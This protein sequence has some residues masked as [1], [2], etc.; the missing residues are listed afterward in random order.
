M[1]TSHSWMAHDLIHDNLG[2]DY[3][4]RNSA[5]SE[6]EE[7]TFVANWNVKGVTT[8]K[9]CNRKHLTKCSVT[10]PCHPC[11]SFLAISP[12]DSEMYSR[13][14]ENEI[15]LGSSSSATQIIFCRSFHLA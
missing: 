3:M 4:N 15:K 11:H 13:I 1:W 12:S 2:G 10:V 6:W 5:S 9:I 7:S 8:A 14:A